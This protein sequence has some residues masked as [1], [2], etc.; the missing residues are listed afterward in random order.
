[1]QTIDAKAVHAAG[2]EERQAAGTNF[3]KIFNPAR[4]A[5]VGVSSE[6][7]AVGFGNGLLM[8]LQAM[9]FGGDI[10][11]VNP[12]G[13]TFAGLE[14]YKRVEDIPGE[15][16]FAVL[17]LAARLVPEVLEACRIKGAAGA[18]IISS[19]FSELGTA[20]GLALEA[21]IT[22]IAAR[23]IRVI[24]PNCFGI[25]CPKSG[26]TF[27]PNPDLSRESGSVAFLSQSG[28]MASDFANMGKWL[29]LRFSKVVSF[30][31]GVD[32]RETGLLQYLDR[33]EETRVIAMYIEGIRDGEQFFQT[34]KSVAGRKPVIVYKGG[35]SQA[36]Q[37]AVVSH[38]ASMGGSRVIWPSVLRQVHAIQVQDMQEMAQASLAFARLPEKPVRCISVVGGGGALG[39]AACDAAE[40][41][42]ITIPPFSGDLKTRIEA[43]LPKP[44]SS[45]ANPVDVANPYV[46]PKV[47][48]E[49]LRLAATDDR[50]DLQV[51]ISLLYHF[52]AIA[53]AQGK[54]VAAVTPYLELADVIRDV[55]AETGKPI[56]VVLPNPRRGLDEMDVV[57]M[58]EKTRQAFIDRGILVMDEIRDALRAIG[59]V[60]AYYSGREAGYE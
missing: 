4:L 49:V 26:L 56:I 31:N 12:K 13:G 44:G 24:G 10:F 42:G 53:R 18:E 40:F 7:A 21:E 46:P 32:L 6:G 5:I 58:V 48:K 29:G 28:G 59:H 51:M 45:A 35:L 17:A 20:E 37:R 15:I 1:M 43:L 38:T 11:P 2:H 16:D 47:L 55:A 57:E 50:I 9:G 22:K 39:V 52:K 54:P 27:V 41:Y 14:I 33:D 8:A 19:G 60:N 34:I 25:Y 36:G 23:G 30:G 3:N